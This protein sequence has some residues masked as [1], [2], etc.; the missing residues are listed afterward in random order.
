MRN[1]IRIL[2]SGPGLIGRQHALLVQ[3]HPACLLEAIVAPAHVANVEF[4]ESLRVPFFPTIEAALE[5]RDFDGAIISSP[6]AFHA[7]QA[8]ACIQRRVPALVEKPVTDDLQT[9]L[10]LAELSETENVPVLV[11]HH[12]TYSPLLEVAVKF[13]RSPQ[14]GRPVAMQ[15]AALFYKP[16]HYFLD[17]PWRTRI[18]G[19]PI[20]INLIHEVGLM[21]AFFGE[22]ASVFADSSNRVRGFEVEDSVAI[23][24]QFENGALGTFLLSDTATSNRSWEMTSGENIRYP[25]YPESDC[26]HFAGTAGSLDFPS[27]NT[28]FYADGVTPSWWA[29]FEDS[30]LQFE[31]ADPLVRQLDHFIQVIERKVTPRVT[32]RDGYRNMLIIQAI[33][34]SIARQKQVRIA[35]ISY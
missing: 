14:F 34:Q 3:K 33:K 25:H 32:A 11:G 4:A 8:K 29:A 6:N 12:R 23:A 15:G 7:E 9:A 18:G 19:G 1:P 27:M 5:E 31:H 10:Y 24:L 16:E 22:I 35:D 17:G 20:L 21:R 26:Y 13:L 2:L 28:R 30:K